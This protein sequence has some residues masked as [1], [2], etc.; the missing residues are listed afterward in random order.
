METTT[1]SFFEQ[2]SIVGVLVLG[3]FGLLIAI[4]VPMLGR[5]EPDR[6]GPADGNRLPIVAARVLGWALV[7]ISVIQAVLLTV[8]SKLK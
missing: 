1:G 4:V 8:L 5:K 2:G 6:G 7:A 3:G